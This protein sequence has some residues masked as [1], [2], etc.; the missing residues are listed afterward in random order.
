MPK[1]AEGHRESFNR[2]RQRQRQRRGRREENP[3][4]F[5]R[6]REESLILVLPANEDDAVLRIFAEISHRSKF[7]ANIVAN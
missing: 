2:E 4:L 5:D 1:N 3:K 6:D 7:V